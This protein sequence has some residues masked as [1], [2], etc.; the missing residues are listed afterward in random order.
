M[1]K[2]V[3]PHRQAQVLGYLH[4]IAKDGIADARQVAIAEA[5][6]TTVGTVSRAVR[7][8]ESAGLIKVES[9]HMKAQYRIL[10]PLSTPSPQ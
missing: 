6:G 3:S 8:L 7:H 10:T 1:V 9:L 5:I 2:F 4:A